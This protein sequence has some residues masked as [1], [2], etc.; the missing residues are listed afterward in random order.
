MHCFRSSPE[1]ARKLLE[2]FPNLYI[3]VTGVLTTSGDLDKV[4]AEAVPIDR[5]LL[6]TD[7][8]YMTPKGFTGVCMPSMC[9]AIAE[10]IAELKELPLAVALLQLRENTTGMYGV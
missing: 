3:G 8:P 2:N 5:L 4:V 10:R 1:C 6:E 7:A 9:I